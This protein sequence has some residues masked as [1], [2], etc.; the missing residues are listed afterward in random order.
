MS[1]EVRE[2][3]K[4]LLTAGG[5]ITVVGLL[6]LFGKDIPFLGNLPGDFHFERDNFKVFI[7]L[8]TALLISL[9]G[10]IVLNLIL[11]IINR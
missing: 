7:P 3:G 9:G 10:T 2:L 1:P 8:G 6:L 4:L 5:F 11:W